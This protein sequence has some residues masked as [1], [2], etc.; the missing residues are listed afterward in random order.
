[1]K[2]DPN[3]LAARN[4]TADHTLRNIPYGKFLNFHARL[5]V[6]PCSRWKHGKLHFSRKDAFR[7]R[8]SIA[9]TKA[10]VFEN[11]D[12]SRCGEHPFSIL[13]KRAMRHM[14]TAALA[15]S[16]LSSVT[17]MAQP[18]NQDRNDQGDNRNEQ[19]NNDQNRKDQGRKGATP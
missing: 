5:L 11:H 14:L 12:E 19:N 16:L 2:R 10:K 4:A 1:M 13:R 17:V 9:K 6:A 3:L 18:N 7:S 8:I 15:L